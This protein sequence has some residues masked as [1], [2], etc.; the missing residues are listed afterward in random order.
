MFPL[1]VFH[2]FLLGVCEFSVF[3]SGQR[4]LV[5]ASSRKKI[6]LE[7][8]LA[9]KLVGL[10]VA[11]VTTV[12]HRTE[13]RESRTRKSTAQDPVPVAIPEPVEVIS[14][15][16]KTLL[17]GDSTVEH[18]SRILDPDGESAG[19]IVVA[20]RVAYATRKSDVRS[21]I[22]NLMFFHSCRG[23]L[24]RKIRKKFLSTSNSFL[25]HVYSHSIFLSLFY[26]LIPFFL[27]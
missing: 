7:I 25:S 21:S 6:S 26:I 11:S 9:E 15:C 27:T 22:F 19:D 24:Q 2:F 20:G 18:F 8:N 17:I 16:P 13:I 1:F 12:D 10:S 4:A 3:Q 5:A 14:K 23:L